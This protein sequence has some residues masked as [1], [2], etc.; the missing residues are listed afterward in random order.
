M[1]RGIGQL[2]TRKRTFLR[3]YIFGKGDPLRPSRMEQR[4]PAS[5]TAGEAAEAEWR[6]AAE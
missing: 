2:A 5:L 6:E 3:Q 4:I 1:I